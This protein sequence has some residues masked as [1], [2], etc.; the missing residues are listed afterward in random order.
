MSNYIE[1]VAIVE[2]KTEW[3]TLSISVYPEGHTDLFVTPDTQMRKVI[4]SDAM[5]KKTFYI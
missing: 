3:I 4:E 5:T 1:V 2:G